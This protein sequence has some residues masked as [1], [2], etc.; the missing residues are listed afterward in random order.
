MQ[1][2]HFHLRKT[3]LQ[4]CLSIFCLSIIN[5]SLLNAAG[6]ASHPWE[7]PSK[8][9]DRHSHPYSPRND[10]KSILDRDHSLKQKSLLGDIWDDMR[11]IVKEPD[12]YMIVGGMAATPGMFSS[13]FKHESP[14]FS[15]MWGSS[16]FADE[17]FEWGAGMGNFGYHFG[18]ALLSYFTG[19][20]AH[21][22]TLEKFGFDLFRAQTI[23]GLATLSLKGIVN[24]R[25][26][27][28]NPFS[29]P[30]GHTSTAFTTATVIYHDFGPLWG[31]AAYVG[32]TYIGFSR[33]QENKHYMSDVIG[34]AILGTY[35][36][37]KILHRKNNEAG[38]EI[39][40]Y[41]G[42]DIRGL[43]LQMRF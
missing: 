6:H 11:Y 4:F 25:R 26:P 7:S 27:D 18:T 36:S 12:F 28:G 23:N 24:R 9:L 33:L 2:L 13:A 43:N 20:A 14:E 42:E 32:A 34:G 1:I 41:E 19:K 15:E 21:S 8:F 38:L 17:F 16:N 30:S 10:N 39:S 5:C 37:F 22:A 40:P 35:L 31:S 29:F 3:A